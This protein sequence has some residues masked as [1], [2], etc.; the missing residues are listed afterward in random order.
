MQLANLPEHP[1]SVPINM[2]VKV[3]GTP[4]DKLDD[5]EPFEFIRTI[6]IARIMMPAS[7]VRLSAGRENMSEQTQA[8]C[9]MA[10]ANSIFYGC[11]LLT[12]SNPD[13]HEDVVLFK[14][15]GINTERTRDYSDEAHELLL[16]E[17]LEQQQQAP[18]DLFYDATAGK[19]AGKQAETV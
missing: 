5:M 7:H 19:P 1:Q 8:L 10:G 14:K 3:D 2:L 4:L 12:T 15:L 17:A 9:F 13:T 11:K 16:E 6:A 18:E